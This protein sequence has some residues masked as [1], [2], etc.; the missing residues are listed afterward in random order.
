MITDDEIMPVGKLYK[1]HGI[2][3]EITAGFDYDV[4]LSTLRCIIL[5]IDGIFVPFF[6]SSVRPKN[7]D[8]DLLTIDGIESEQQASL[9]VNKTVYALKSDMAELLDGDDD[10]LY[11]DDLVGFEVKVPDENFEGEIVDVDDST[12]NTLLIVAP[13]DKADARVY[14]PLADDFITAIDESNRSL[15][16]SLPTGLL[17][18]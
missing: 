18:L 3:G 10:R 17:T 14:I 4:D 16:M 1:P 9:L 6:V 5:D 8:C 15:T 7:A 13:R 11:V 2:K 12:D